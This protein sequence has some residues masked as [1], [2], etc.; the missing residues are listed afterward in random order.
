LTAKAPAK[1]HT[2]KHTATS[3]AS[4]SKTTAKHAPAKQKKPATAKAKGAAV[5]TAAKPAKPAKPAGFA[6]GDLLPVCALE[7]VA[8]SLR[9]AGEPVSRS[10]VAA[11]WEA[12]GSPDEGVTIAE[13]LAAFG[14]NIPHP[15]PGRG[16][17]PAESNRLGAWKGPLTSWAVRRLERLDQTPVNLPVIL[18]IDVP[19]SHAVLA[20]PDGWWSWGALYSPWDAR[21]EEAWGV[22]WG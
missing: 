6:I 16:E 20:T 9:L 10:D 13:A 17:G 11:L 7:A 14:A 8:Q 18:R 4:A 1:G 5:H 19:G 2:A 15:S 21:V 22:S 12:A 3:K